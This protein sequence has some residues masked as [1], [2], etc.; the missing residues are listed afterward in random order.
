MVSIPG[1]SI[2]MF[3]NLDVDK[4]NMNVNEIVGLPPHEHCLFVLIIPAALPFPQSDDWRTGH[5]VTPHASR[6]IRNIIVFI[7]WYGGCSPNI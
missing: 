3:L 4:I 1:F 2:K 6:E 7:G 5:E